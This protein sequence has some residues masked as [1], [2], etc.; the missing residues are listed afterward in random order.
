MNCDIYSTVLLDSRLLD[1][2]KMRGERSQPGLQ[3]VV[4]EADSGGSGESPGPGE[5]LLLL[6]PQ[7]AGED[8]Q[9]GHGDVPGVEAEV[10]HAQD[11]LPASQEPVLATLQNTE[12]A[13]SGHFLQLGPPAGVHIR[14]QE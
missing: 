2:C 13:R 5:Q 3:C 1:C 7:V 11:S 8:V 10:Q 12:T 6:A 9:L 14:E 4:S